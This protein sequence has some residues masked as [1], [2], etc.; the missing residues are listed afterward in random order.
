MPTND[1]L[2]SFHFTIVIGTFALSLTG[3]RNSCSYEN[4]YIQ[5]CRHLKKGKMNGFFLF[6]TLGKF[7]L[8]CNNVREKKHTAAIRFI[9]CAIICVYLYIWYFQE[10]DLSITISNHF[11]KINNLSLDACIINLV[12]CLCVFVKLWF[13]EKYHHNQL[14]R[15]NSRI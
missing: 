1:Y 7:E 6:L 13:H 3:G 11:E 5:N 9:V 8:F 12:R 15:L 14:L 2:S 10:F 4:I